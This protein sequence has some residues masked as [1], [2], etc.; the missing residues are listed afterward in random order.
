ME[1]VIEFG[2]RALRSRT[3]THSEKMRSEMNNG[4]EAR[5]R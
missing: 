5:H 4:L 1:K 2:N 3:Y